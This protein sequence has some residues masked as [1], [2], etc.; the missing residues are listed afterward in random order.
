M[1]GPEIYP[2]P[3]RLVKN[4]HHIDSLLPCLLAQ[5]LPLNLVQEIEV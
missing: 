5:V 4:I 3:F 1:R 2:E